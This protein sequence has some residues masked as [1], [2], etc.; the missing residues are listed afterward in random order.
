MTII[1][2]VRL[3]LKHLVLLI[4]VPLFLGLMVILLTMNP[5]Y[6]F[7]SQTILYTGLATG[8]S[9][10]MDKKYNYQATN[11]AFDNLI[12]IIKSRETQEEVAVRLLAIHLML[13]EAN[14]K[15]ISKELYE[16]LKSKVPEEIYN[17]IENGTNGNVMTDEIL[18]VSDPFPEEIDRHNY[19]KT[20]QNL[21]TLM[22]SGSDNFIYELLNYE[23]DNHYS[24]NAIS[25]IEVQRINN[26]DLLKLSYTVNDPGI[27]Q[28]TLAI[29]NSVCTVN[30][31]HIK[32]N[33]SGSVVKYFET[34]LNKAKI[35]LKEAE[36]KLLEFN[37]SSNIINYYEQSKA[38]AV[39][40]EELEVDY[41]MK[42]A[43]LAGLEAGTK[44]LED[45]LQMQEV[46]QIKSN[47]ILDKQKELGDLNYEIA[48]TQAEI[49]SS[50]NDADLIKM[51][52]LKNQ[53]ELLTNAIK[54]GID[55]LYSYQNS[56]DGLQ[57]S[58]VL[59]DWMSNVV[60]TENLKAK[61]KV[62]DAQKDDFQEVYANYAPAG[63]NMKRLEREI[64]V[65]EQGYLEIL[66]GLNLAKLKL[67]DSELSSSL[68]TVDE[69]YYPLSP[70]PTKRP[71]LIIA[72]A[73]IGGILTLGIIFVME[74]F[75]DTLKNSIKAS[76][77]TGLTSLGMIPKIILDPGSINLPIIQK[78][79]I[80]II[81]QNILQYFGVQNSKQKPKT[82]IVFSTQK[83]EGKTVLAGNIAKT[84]K[85]EGKKVLLLNYDEQKE[86]LKQQRKSPI[87]NKILGYPDPR[88]DL[89]NLFLADASTYLDFSEHYS[90]AMNS[91]FYGART[92]T[93]IL[94]SNN[95]V[96]DYT[97]DFVII[98]LP[99]I[100]Y[101]NYPAEL[102]SNADLD[103]LVCRSNR[104]WS[105]ADE[106][107]ISNLREACGPKLNIIVNGVK[108]NEIESVLGDLPKKRTKFRKKLKS[109]FKFQFLSKN[110]I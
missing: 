33:R 99:A 38:V 59:P 66:H 7:S 57:I 49:E 101:Y 95:I 37:K 64:A 97:P 11:S 94:E 56:I 70:N 71:I 107:A 12:N 93:D 22:R 67:Q 77:E 58:Q 80:E 25:K 32:E 76:K 20:V 15:Y 17:Y 28:Q 104:I 1:E 44:R 100:I 36:S 82:I 103:I 90:Y 21:L 40:K 69:P 86:P 14:P 42:T 89:D 98:E 62:I 52:R 48:L 4:V 68:K 55:E 73:F 23:D 26:S 34:E 43:E 6:E 24:L 78:R 84:L 53:G 54:K 61:I 81:T 46:I 110:Q 35:S 109:I 2:F 79:V 3:I 29:Y 106:S 88:I 41:K 105:D 92:Y 102:I 63:A 39:V 9:I 5:S 10:Q 50:N 30:Y 72:A 83:L 13:P 19:E 60:E 31:K 87:I 91:K 16:K 74:Y 51:V 8:S 27:C 45:K 65:A 18:A 85:Q 108:L 75:D 47:S 96:L